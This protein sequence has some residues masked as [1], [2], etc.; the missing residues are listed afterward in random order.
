MV[1]NLTMGATKERK[2]G[3][4]MGKR[5][6]KNGCNRCGKRLLRQKGKKLTEESKSMSTINVE[7]GLW[8]VLCCQPCGMLGGWGSQAEAGVG[9]I[10]GWRTLAMVAG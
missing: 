2:K 8:L 4:G 10:D 1:T 9:G 3:G 7:R 6:V 5:I